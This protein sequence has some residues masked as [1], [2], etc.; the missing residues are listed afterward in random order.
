MKP[1][2]CHCIVGIINNGDCYNNAT[3]FMYFNIRNGKFIRT[4]Y[5]HY[6]E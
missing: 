3:Y 4:P 2:H 5:S 1:N 6:Y